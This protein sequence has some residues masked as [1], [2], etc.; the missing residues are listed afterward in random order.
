M[1]PMLKAVIHD[2][3]FNELRVALLGVICWVQGGSILTCKDLEVI[4]FEA[5]RS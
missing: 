1:K 2:M 3:S 5:K 4:L